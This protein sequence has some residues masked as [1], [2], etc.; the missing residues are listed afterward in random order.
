MTLKEAQ[1]KMKQDMEILFRGTM[2]AVCNKVIDDTPIDTTNA[3]G[4]WQGSLGQPT[5]NVISP[6]SAVGRIEDPEATLG[7]WTFGQ[8]AYFS[9]SVPYIEL[10]EY[11][12]SDQAP[13]GM[14]RVNVG[15]AQAELDRQVKKLQNG[16]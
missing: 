8:A 13:N 9:N 7:A 3:R 5:S 4:N 15:N 14:V 12:W 10:L 1:Q 6:T 16:G 2:I 11:G